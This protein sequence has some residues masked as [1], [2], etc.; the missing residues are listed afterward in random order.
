MC[1]ALCSKWQVSNQNPPP[2]VAWLMWLGTGMRIA[3]HLIPVNLCIQYEYTAPSP[4]LMAKLT[5]G[6][7]SVGL[8]HVGHRMDRGVLVQ[9]PASIFHTVARHSSQKVCPQLS[10]QGSINTSKQ[11]G[12]ELKSCP[13]SSPNALPSDDICLLNNVPLVYLPS[14]ST[15]EDSKIRR[16]YLHPPLHSGG[17]IP[18]VRM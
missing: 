3:R 4:Y 8:R 14:I 6:N 17:G 11:M 9:F 7:D 1:T 10:E 5:W 15:P 16:D 2:H 13:S 12:H 18:I